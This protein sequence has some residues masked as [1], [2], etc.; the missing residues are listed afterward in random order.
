MC[1]TSSPK[2]WWESCVLWSEL[3][4][5]KCATHWLV[6]SLLFL[7][8]T[9]AQHLVTAAPSYTLTPIGNVA[10]LAVWPSTCET[11]PLWHQSRGSVW[12]YGLYFH[13]I[14]WH[15]LHLLFLLQPLWSH[16]CS[17]VLHHRSLPL[18][19]VGLVLVLPYRNLSSSSTACGLNV[20]FSSVAG[21]TLAF[22]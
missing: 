16:H 9:P 19:A 17:K 6:L 11:S 13:W 4:N 5:N 7:C 14:L 1:C 15:Y 21:A 12:L 2:I 8:P 10:P 20:C 22:F 3:D 18:G